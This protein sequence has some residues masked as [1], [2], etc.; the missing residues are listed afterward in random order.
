MLR[1]W[2]SIS[3]T[4]HCIPSVTPCP[5]VATIGLMLS[6]LHA[7]D[8]DG[9]DR[10]LSTFAKDSAVGMSILFENTR[11]GTPLISGFWITCSSSFFAS[12]NLSGSEESTT[13]MSP[14]AS[15]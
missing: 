5:V 13:K 11:M 4:S 1:G 14:C 10:T 3:S 7:C 15:L 2:D 9:S 6:A 8:S 12:S